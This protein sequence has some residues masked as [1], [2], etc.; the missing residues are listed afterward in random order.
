M[1]TLINSNDLDHLSELCALIIGANHDEDILAR[2]L[3]FE[4]IIV[5]NKG[6]ETYMRQHIAAS[7]AGIA[8]G[9]EFTQLWTFIWQVHKIVHHAD[10]LNRFS[11]EYIIHTLFSLK[12]VW[13]SDPLFKRLRHYIENDDASQLKT[14]ELC[15]KIADTFDQYQMYRPDWLNQWEKFTAED[16]EIFQKNPE[17]DGAIKKWLKQT[18]RHH[19]ALYTLLV[20]NIWQAKLWNMLVKAIKAKGLKD[21][22]NCNDYMTRSEVIYDLCQHNYSAD[23]IKHLPKRLFI[24][25]VTAIPAYIYDFLNKISEHLQIF[26]MLLNPC[27]SYWGDI[28]Y[29]KGDDLK[30]HKEITINRNPS[31]LK[32]HFSEK[33]K[34][35]AHT[36]LKSQSLEK[37]DYDSDKLTA[38][39]SYYELAE[40]NPLLL[41]LGREGKEN[42]AIMYDRIENIH[43]VDSFPENEPNCLLNCLKNH[44]LEN[45]PKSSERTL[46]AD[47]DTSIEIHSCHT[48][49]R[50]VEILR[51]AILSRFKQAQ[52]RAE[53]LKPRDILIMVP[54]IEAYAP[55]IEAV[56]GGIDKNDPCYIPYAISDR[57]ANNESPLA[58]A[59]LRLLA[60]GQTPITASFIISLLNVKAVAEKFDLKAED[61]ALITSWCVKASIH[62]GLNK[63]DL[64][65]NRDCKKAE[66]IDLPWTFEH[67]LERMLDG[68]AL[69]VN[70]ENSAYIDIE[71][72]DSLTLGKFA[73][74]ITRIKNLKDNFPKELSFTDNDENASRPLQRWFYE[75]VL[76][77]FFEVEDPKDES[78]LMKIKT[79]IGKI[80]TVTEEFAD[81]ENKQ[82][83]I[84]LLVFRRMLEK[85][86][87]NEH[88]SVG[89]LRE[90]MNFCSLIPMRAIPFKHIFIMGLND[91]TFPRNSNVPG[92]N[93]L[94]NASLR[95]YGDRSQ[96]IDDRY[97]FLEAILSAQ[98]SFYISYI[99]QN[100]LDLSEMYPSTVVSEL[101]DY[102]ADNFT[103]LSDKEQSSAISDSKYRSQIKERLVKVEHLNAYD[104]KNFIKEECYP[105]LPSFDTS[106]FLPTLTLDKISPICLASGLNFKRILDESLDID[107]DDLIFFSQNPARFFLKKALNLN[108]E[109]FAQDLPIDD[110]DFN[111]NT[112]SLGNLIAECLQ[113]KNPEDQQAFLEKRLNLAKANGQMPY[114]VFFD[115]Q[116]QALADTVTTMQSL[117]L[118]Y[119]LKFIADTEHFEL[120]RI[121][122]RVLEHD[123]TLRLHGEIPQS[124]LVL[125][126][127][128][129]QLSPKRLFRAFITGLILSKLKPETKPLCGVLNQGSLNLLNLPTGDLADKALIELL[130]LY[131]TGLIRPQIGGDSTLQNL[132]KSTKLDD[133][134][135]I[136][137]Q[138]VF[139][140]YDHSQ[141]YL[142]LDPNVAHHGEA[143]IK[144]D[145]AAYVNFYMN[146]INS[147]LDKY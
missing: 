19:H 96:A 58:D 146:Y 91:N 116:K 121:K 147:A 127:Y 30:S 128:K 72:S 73:E 60:C 15:W 98:Q 81:D 88:D 51:N 24:I 129:E 108:I 80:R 52:E 110:E 123:Y 34:Q 113:V 4:H 142:F 11:H 26:Y 118:T 131:I 99:G 47:D 93:L 145:L 59:V 39:F 89:Y 50:E 8:A 77:Q 17:F 54:D 40:G 71:G 87:Q 33:Y 13:K 43:N 57:A 122:L 20:D 32:P 130:S 78:D 92:F 45:K 38:S 23:E 6:M 139:E 101:L 144:E 36:I 135:D 2:C 37:V 66:I 83:K 79:I 103:I 61:V 125:N 132:K 27:Q 137:S 21:G 100:P 102:I 1:F 115:K 86:L 74:F 106:S 138:L 31:G 42:L 95:R 70:T 18:S 7:E 112:L 9:I 114:G 48:I 25:G 124:A 117:M 68:Y 62:R 120:P 136:Y 28:C 56:F 55:Y 64:S 84:S 46:I 134:E 76:N 14:Y 69:G 3:H 63:H 75:E 12:A 119:D 82:N 140:K 104:P 107:Y 141:S 126:V 35:E 109:S 67:G 22:H 16:F 65:E 111:L 5:M 85:A 133:P 143:A 44:L 105:Y 90:K 10:D 29:R 49:K 41:S 94:S 53:T 97:I